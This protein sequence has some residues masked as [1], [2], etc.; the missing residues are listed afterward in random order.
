MQERIN[1]NQQCVE[2]TTHRGLQIL[3]G[4]LYLQK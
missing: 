1:N 2:I 3:W 4:C